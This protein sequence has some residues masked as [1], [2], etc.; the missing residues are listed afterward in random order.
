MDKTSFRL[1]L[2]WRVVSAILF[3]SLIIAIGLW[4]PWRRTST[5]TI[6]V[7]GQATV[8]QAPDLFRFQPMFQDSDSAKLSATGNAAVAKLKSLGVKDADIKTNVTTATQPRATPTAEAK[9]YQSEPTYTID[10]T[11]TDKALAQKATDYLAAS[12]ATGLITPQADFQKATRTKLDRAAR[13]QAS[14]DAKDKAKVMAGQL[15]VKLGKVTK[16]SEG[17]G[18]I[19]PLSAGR[20]VAN[21]LSVSSSAASTPV[22]QPGTNEVAYSFSV[23]FEIR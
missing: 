18:G 3:A 8:E 12:G 11:V 17:G 23:E 10:F 2:D 19:M 7:T 20:A 16:I 13:E 14:A 9:L 22:I 6:T 5:K 15:G 4:Q 21:D 1:T